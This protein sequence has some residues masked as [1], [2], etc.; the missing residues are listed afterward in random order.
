MIENKRGEL[1]VVFAS[2]QMVWM[3][4][5]SD[6]SR[7]LDA[8]LEPDGQFIPIEE[9]LSKQRLASRE[10]ENALGKLSR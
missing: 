9:R 4:S 8:M 2:S 7:I 6:I 1:P 10:K 3:V 5:T